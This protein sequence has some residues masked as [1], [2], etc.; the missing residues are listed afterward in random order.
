MTFNVSE[1][2]VILAQAACRI[3]LFGNWSDDL[4]FLSIINSRIISTT[5]SFSPNR[6]PIR[7]AL[8][9]TPNHGL[10]YRSIDLNIDKELIYSDSLN[11][12]IFNAFLQAMKITNEQ[13]F[14]KFVSD[15]QG[16]Q[17]LSYCEPPFRSGLGSSSS[18]MVSATAA[19]SQFLNVVKNKTEIA[20]SSYKFEN[21]INKVGWQDHYA[22]AFGGANLISRR[23]NDYNGEILP[24]SRKISNIICNHGVILFISKSPHDDIQWVA[25]N[26]IWIE[27]IKR[28]DQIVCEFL[29]INDVNINKVIELLNIHGEIAMNWYSPKLVLALK[30][31]IQS[32]N[33]S[34]KA[35]VFVGSGPAALIL[36]DMPASELHKI[37]MGYNKMECKRIYPSVSGVKMKV[38]TQAEVH[39]YFNS[40]AD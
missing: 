30:T 21:M 37:F 5:I 33:V 32:I 8:Y 17:L 9:R 6:M 22:A 29:L 28:M 3:D 12:P 11:N 4:D 15:E 24:L 26:N 13:A 18:L 36:T 38:I 31:I 2:R 40:K 10:F 14:E 27:R 16:I 23:I 7:F 34:N 25:Q 19:F 1:N 35:G 20:E 39:N